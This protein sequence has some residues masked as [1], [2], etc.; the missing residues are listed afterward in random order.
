MLLMESMPPA[1]TPVPTVTTRYPTLNVLNVLFSVL[2]ATVDQPIALPVSTDQYQ[3][4]DPA[5]SPAAKT[6]SVSVEFALP[7]RPVATAANTLLRTA[8]N[9]LQVTFKQ[10]QSARRVASPTNTTTMLSKNASAAV[11]AVPPAPPKSSV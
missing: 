1:L 4:T 11:L 2:P 6:N 7:V 3:P 10:V 5:Q 9:A 8:C